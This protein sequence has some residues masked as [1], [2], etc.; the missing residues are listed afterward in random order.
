[1]S[2][3]EEEQRALA[4]QR[5]ERERLAAA[6][7]REAALRGDPDAYLDAIDRFGPLA[8]RDPSRPEV[9]P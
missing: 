9:T 2:A 4:F 6:A 5:A 8:R 7:A 1:M 3:A